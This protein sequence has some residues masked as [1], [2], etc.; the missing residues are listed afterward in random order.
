MTKYIK[1]LPI[2]MLGR[3]AGLAAVTICATVMALAVAIFGTAQAHAETITSNEDWTVTFT[4][5]ETMSSNFNSADITEFVGTMQPGDTANVSVALKNQYAKSTDWYMTNKII[6]SLE[7]SANSAGGGSYTYNLV[8][9][10]PDGQRTTLFSSDTVGGDNSAGDRSGL[11]EASDA[12][13]DYFFLG[14]IP[15][16]GSAK[17]DLTVALDGETQGNAY[18]N[19][20][21]DLSLDFAVET[22]DGTTTTTNPPSGD[23]PGGGRLQQTGDTN[24]MI[25]AL[26]GAAA[27]AGIALLVIAIVGRR[28]RNAEEGE[29][30]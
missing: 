21:A 27:V 10:D 11:R 28:K 19:T 6:S 23:N 22:N 8:Y 30:R 5:N 2:D 18:Q 25:I 3:L 24:M 17:V 15:T 13:E 14:T 7:E 26:C 20:L 29:V 4:S 16:N 1:K 9:T 12:L